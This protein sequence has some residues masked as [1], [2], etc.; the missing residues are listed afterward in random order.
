MS[1]PYAVILD[2]AAAPA[3]HYEQIQLTT[4][5]IGGANIETNF[6]D[7]VNS[8]GRALTSTEDDW[9]DLLAAIYAADLVCP[10]GLN[11]DYTRQI[12]LSLRMRN[13]QAIRPSLPAVEEAFE[14]L[15][16][17]RLT[18][19]VEDWQDQPPN[20]FPS[21]QQPPAAIDAV[22]LLSGG[23]DSATTA[24]RLA[25]DGATPCFVSSETAGHVIASQRRVIGD[26]AA[27]FPVTIQHAGFSVKLRTR[28]TN[29]LRPTREASQR[30][31]TML[32]VGVASL[33][34]AARRVET[35]TVGENGIMAINAPLT[36]G[37]F[38]PFSTHTA[39]P[40]VLALLGRLA[41]NVLGVTVGVTNPSLLETKTEVVRG[42]DNMGLG[43]LVART[44]SCWIARQDEHCG[45]CVPCL[46]RRFAVT[47][48]GV[49]DVTYQR[50]VFI[51]RWDP[52]D[53]HN[54]DLADYMSFVR[55]IRSSN[56]VELV[57]NF[58]ELAIPGGAAH[59]T[60]AIE[61]YRRW[62]SD[63]EAVVRAQP[64][65]AGLVA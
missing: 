39:H 30:A 64:A 3:G 61:M 57:V 54:R 50:D 46:V 10:R 16:Q 56:D 40:H 45:V 24:A 17:D 29:P 2:G 51:Q 59:R 5:P 41:S 31:R 6:R 49:P 8:I 9:L 48:V 27:H 25:R 52:S 37:R 53:P 47:T 11:E 23:L 63:V 62:A 4:R 65:I 38:G 35:V 18:I 55:T 36:G 33:I 22:A 7:V 20:R 21:R 19:R 43:A 32:F 1:G 28:P 44:H 13:A 58:A 42:L 15:C 34:A 12:H 60:R 14:R 26:L